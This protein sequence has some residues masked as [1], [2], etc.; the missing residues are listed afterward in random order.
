MA[1]TVRGEEIGLEA[2]FWD[3]DGTLVDTERHWTAVQTELVESF[4]GTWTEA[5]A[6][7]IMGCSQAD[8]IK[9]LQRAGVRLSDDEIARRVTGGVRDRISESVHWRPGA[10]ELLAGLRAHGVPCVLVTMSH[11]HIVGDILNHFPADS[12]ELA[13]TGDMVSQGKPHPEAYETAFRRLERIRPQLSSRRVI[14][15]EDSLPGT[16]AA[17]AAGLPTIGVPHLAP[18]PAADGLTIWPTLAGRGVPDLYAVIA[19]SGHGRAEGP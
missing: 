6:L 5:Q 15:I 3:L 4:G 7:S 12:F 14:A 16:R 18:L 17:R 9:V 13:V 19:A 8:S 1:A 11:R 2:V 10:A